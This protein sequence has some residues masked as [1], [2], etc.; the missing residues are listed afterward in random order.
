MMEKGKYNKWVTNA[1]E[2]FRQPTA[3][4]VQQKNSVALQLDTNSKK[5]IKNCATLYI[6]TYI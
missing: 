2:K 3:E 5:Q 1:W 4:F 6:H